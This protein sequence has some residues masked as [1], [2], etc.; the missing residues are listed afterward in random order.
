MKLMTL[1]EARRQLARKAGQAGGRARW[2]KVPPKQRR[3]IMRRMGRQ[4]ARQA[5]RGRDGRFA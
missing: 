1:E 5:R 4:R 3:T 2:R